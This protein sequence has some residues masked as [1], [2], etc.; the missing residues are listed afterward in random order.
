[1]ATHNVTPSAVVPVQEPEADAINYDW[2]RIL[3]S[4]LSPVCTYPACNRPRHR[5]EYREALDRA[6]KTL[7]WKRKEPVQ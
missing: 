7:G 2:E 4:Y 3:K 1:M 5:E 6:Y